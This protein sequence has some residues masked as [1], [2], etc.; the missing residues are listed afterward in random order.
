MTDNRRFGGLN[1]AWS[2]RR[3]LGTAALGGAAAFAAACGSGNDSTTTSKA[4]S[5]PQ[6]PAAAA[7]SASSAA[8]AAAAD[9]RQKA[10]E[11]VVAAGKKEGR[12]SVNTFPGD[13]F[14]KALRFFNQKYPD[15]KLEQ[16]NLHS[17]DFAP[18]LRQEREAG[19][20]TWD[21]ALIPTTTALQ[22]LKPIGAWDPA[23]PAIMDPAVMKDELWDGGFEAGFAIVQDKALAY[24]FNVASNPTVRIN[25]DMVQ[26]GEIKSAKDLLNPKWKGKILLADVRTMGDTFWP[27]TAARKALGDDYLKQLF[28]DQE[29]TLSRDTRQ[30]AEFMVRNRFPVAIGPSAVVLKDFLGQGLGKNLKAIRVPEM[31]TQSFGSVMWLL[32]KAPHP[33]AA[34]VFMSWLLTKEAQIPWAKETESNSRVKGV[35]P[36]NPEAVPPAG[37][38]LFQIDA[39]ENLAEV[40]KTQDI[41]KAVIK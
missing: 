12:V 26:D 40:I 17:Q 23:R 6:A 1:R 32:N 33:N 5:A 29:P 11:D 18:R 38:K 27:M 25:T 21:V 31:D 2:R 22:V 9:P 4:T 10:W 35:E 15:I 24:G 30:M 39:E 7:T 41:A 20:Y 3:V 8:P 37:V 13:G 36:G 19:I 14:N 34:R 16:T 28:V